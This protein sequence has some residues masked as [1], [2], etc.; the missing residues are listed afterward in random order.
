MNGAG[1]NETDQ[2]SE[3]STR[4]GLKEVLPGGKG[5]EK[6]TGKKR[7]RVLYVLHLACV[8]HADQIV[9]LT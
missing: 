9:G 2:A 4:P 5:K 8:L 1:E 6:L 3:L 7:Q